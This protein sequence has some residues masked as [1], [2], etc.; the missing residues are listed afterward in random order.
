MGIL[1]P[2]A[3]GNDKLLPMAVHEDAVLKPLLDSGTE[4]VLVLLE[5]I[6]NLIVHRAVGVQVP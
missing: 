6:K 1:W 3:V 4:L 5:R 2:D